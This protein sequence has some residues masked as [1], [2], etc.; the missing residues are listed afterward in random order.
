M[1]LTKSL[2]KI[3]GLHF[4]TCLSV[5]SAVGESMGERA[6][7]HPMLPLPALGRAGPAP[8]FGEKLFLSVGAAVFSWSGTSAYGS[9]DCPVQ[10]QVWT[11][12]SLWISPS[13]DSVML[14]C[15]VVMLLFCNKSFWECDGLRCHLQALCWPC[16]QWELQA[17]G[18][19][20]G[21]EGPVWAHAWESAADQSALITCMTVGKIHK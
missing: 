5:C 17:V 7:L 16:G 14:D 4:R 11:G 20:A 6:A 21:K 19:W 8:D 12:W 10:G 18:S 2:S 1:C 9:W 3:S 13:S 15:P